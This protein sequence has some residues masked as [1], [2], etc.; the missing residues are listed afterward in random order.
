MT[1]G[2]WVNYKLK[3]RRHDQ[4][5]NFG[6]WPRTISLAIFSQRFLNISTVSFLLIYSPLFFISFIWT[7]FML[8]RWC[9]QSWNSQ[10]LSDSQNKALSMELRTFSL[11]HLS[12]K[13][14]EEKRSESYKFYMHT[15]DCLMFFFSL[16]ET[17]FRLFWRIFCL[18]IKGCVKLKLE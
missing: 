18:F 4:L 5:R 13:T 3:S 1:P 6:L 17:K 14:G 2:S 9:L 12:F 15:C 8:Q 10:N 16:H 7:Q 11:E